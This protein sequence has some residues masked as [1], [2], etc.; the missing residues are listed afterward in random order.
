MTRLFAQASEKHGAGHVHP[1]LT[2]YL[3]RTVTGWLHAPASDAIHR[4]LL[5]SAAQLATLLGLMSADSGADGLAQHW[6]RTAAHLAA[7]ADDTVTF[8]ITL[9]AMSA[10]AHELG[11][12]ARAVHHLA[13]RAVDATRHTS[14]AVR[15]YTQA[16]FAV[17]QAHDDR[18][19]ALA[20][21]TTAERLY[22]RVQA[23]PGPFTAYPLGTL[24]Y[25]RAQ[26]LSTL[27][28]RQGA[29]AALSASLRHRT[30]TERL[31]TALT[32]AR[33]SETLLA[34]GH[35]EAATPHWQAFL[36]TYSLLHSVRATRRLSTMRQLLRPHSRHHTV[37]HLLIQ[38]GPDRY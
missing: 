34:H 13:E 25:Q 3:H 2:D 36:D 12:H 15:T 29:I 30:P 37:A 35:L 26:T 10:H 9:R 16:H 38:V 4:E 27:G 7:D 22:G 23:A 31:A 11:H 6:Y 1:T 24:H 5:V 32:R 21:L 8:A 28:D 19:S 14:P 18:R 20:A 33:L 17:M